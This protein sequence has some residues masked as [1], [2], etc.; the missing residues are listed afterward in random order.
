MQRH[1]SSGFLLLSG[2]VSAMGLRGRPDVAS[3]GGVV[4]GAHAVVFQLLRILGPLLIV[5]ASSSALKNDDDDEEAD[6]QD[7]GDDTNDNG[8]D[9]GVAGRLLTS[10]TTSGVGTVV[11]GE[12]GQHV[13]S[14]GL[15]S[16]C[17]DGSFR[18]VRDQAALCNG[19]QS[20]SDLFGGSWL[21]SVPMA[22]ASSLAGIQKLSRTEPIL[23]ALLSA[24]S[25]SVQFNTIQ[26]NTT[27]WV[28][29]NGK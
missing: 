23:V 9:L 27:G 2:S 11:A 12:D 18:F 1:I 8:S 19:L 5:S 14:Y 7:A 3:L 24:A 10:V 20:K 17:F 28:L 22:T 29:G 6:K 16:K 21:R 15:R 25:D 13:G 4:H 26:C